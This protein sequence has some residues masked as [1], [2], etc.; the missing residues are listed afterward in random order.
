MI[1]ARFAFAAKSVA[2]TKHFARKQ[3]NSPVLWT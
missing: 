1:A 3:L 2:A